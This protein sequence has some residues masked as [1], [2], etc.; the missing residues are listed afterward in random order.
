[1]RFKGIRRGQGGRPTRLTALVHVR[2]V[3]LVVVPGVATGRWLEVRANA[4]AG[5]LH[6][7]HI[8]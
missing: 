3:Q 7:L 8:S 5:W 6:A 1:M 4:A 2:R